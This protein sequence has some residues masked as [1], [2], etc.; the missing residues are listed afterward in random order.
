MLL[1]CSGGG[2]DDDDSFTCNEATDRSGTYLASYSERSGGTC[3]DI[4]DELGRL[5][6]VNALPAQCTEDAP[7]V[8]SADGCRLDRSFTCCEGYY[9]TSIVAVTEQRDA[10]AATITGT[11]SL[12]I[13]EFDPAGNPVDSCSSLYD[14]TAQRQ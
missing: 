11:L 13:T 12:R 3:G 2:D 8:W 14:M 5:D 9:C 7:D 1:G 10:S 4:P 6:G